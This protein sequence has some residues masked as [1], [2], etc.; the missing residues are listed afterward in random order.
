MIRLIAE[1]DAESF[2]EL[3]KKIDGETEFMLFEDGERSTTIEQQ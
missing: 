2:L 1:R 3:C